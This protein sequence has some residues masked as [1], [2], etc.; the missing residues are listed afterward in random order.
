MFKPTKKQHVV[1]KA[2]ADKNGGGSGGST[3]PLIVNIIRGDGDEVSGDSLDRTWQEIHDAFP[4]VILREVHSGIGGE[5][6]ALRLV[7]SLNE[8]GGLDRTTYIVNTLVLS[9]ASITSYGTYDPNG[10]P[11]Q[12]L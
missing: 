10:Y 2:Y 9:T 5:F 7:T 4:N 3:E 8:E 1:N 6:E 11:N 12:D